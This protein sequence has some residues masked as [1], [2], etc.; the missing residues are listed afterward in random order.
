MDSFPCLEC[1]RLRLQNRELLESLQNMV[2]LFDNAVSRLKL[3]KAFTATHEE[4]ILLARVTLEKYAE[5][6][7][8]ECRSDCRC[9]ADVKPGDVHGCSC[10]TEKR[11][12]ESPKCEWCE[13]GWP[14]AESDP[15]YHESPSPRV[16]SRACRKLSP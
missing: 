15:S 3:G 2:G 8:S 9:C 5:K 13:M 10:H 4:V 12:S 7:K 16:G 11:S 6:P 1:E 14:K